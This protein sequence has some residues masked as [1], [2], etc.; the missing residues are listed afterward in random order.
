MVSVY[1][2]TIKDF[3]FLVGRREPRDYRGSGPFYFRGTE[4]RLDGRGRPD[5]S[6]SPSTRLKEER[7]DFVFK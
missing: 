3:F 5:T 4:R 2:K 6:L 1:T 7:Q